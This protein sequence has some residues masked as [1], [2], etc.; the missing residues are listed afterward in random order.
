MLFMWSH[1]EPWKAQAKGMQASGDEKLSMYGDP[2]WTRKHNFMPRWW[3]WWWWCNW[4]QSWSL[5]K[6]SGCTKLPGLLVQKG[7]GKSM[8][9]M[10]V[11]PGA[12]DRFDSLPELCS[13]L[14]NIPV[15]AVGQK[16]AIQKGHLSICWINST[17]QEPTASWWPCFSWNTMMCCTMSTNQPAT[18]KG[19]MPAT[20]TPVSHSW[21]ED[22]P[23]ASHWPTQVT[24]PVTWNNL[25]SF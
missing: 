15:K 20:N 22:I 24:K 10:S 5:Q 8:R 7:Q 21:S 12:Q 17:A 18:P 1:C 4:S 3:W 9:T 6:P 19:T 23:A 16:G 2:T 25:T 14:D 13:T 11:G